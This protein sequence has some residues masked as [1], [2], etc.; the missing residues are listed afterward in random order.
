EARWVLHR[1]ARQTDDDDAGAA[2]PNVAEAVARYRRVWGDVDA[3]INSAPSLDVECPP[4]DDQPPVNLRWILAHLL[5]E[6]ARHAGHA[7]ILREII[8]G[9]TGR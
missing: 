5:Q 3:A 1:F 4:F 6:T 7:D 8:D 2:A 9:Q